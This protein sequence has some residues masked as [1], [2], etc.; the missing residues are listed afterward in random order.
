MKSLLDLIRD[1]SRVPMNKWGHVK[2]DSN[3]PK[4]ELDWAQSQPQETRGIELGKNI[5][6]K[7][8]YKKK[9]PN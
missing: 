2:Q 4:M 7:D 8:T 5:G 3:S 9:K 1:G 6:E